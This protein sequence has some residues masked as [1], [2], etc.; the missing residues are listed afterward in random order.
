VKSYLVRGGRYVHIAIVEAAIGKPLP[1]G[2]QVHHVNGNRSDNSPGNLV[3]CQDA[4]YHK[5]LHARQAARDAT[6]NPDL[7]PCKFCRSYDDTKAMARKKDKRQEA[8]YHRPC[9]AAYVRAKRAG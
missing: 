4:A 8:Y 6:G 7:R 2:A 1:K 3:A 5:L 9:A